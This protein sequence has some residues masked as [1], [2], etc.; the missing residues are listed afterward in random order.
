MQTPETNT[1]LDIGIHNLS[2]QSLTQQ[3]LQILRKGLSFSPTPV[4]DTRRT[5]KEILSNFDDFSNSLRTS[6]NQRRP[7]PPP[8]YTSKQQTTTTTTNT[9]FI[10]RTMKFI[11]K[12]T[13]RTQVEQFSGIQT[14][15]N[16]IQNTKN[17]LDEALP[18]ICKNTKINITRTQRKVITALQK[19]RNITTI[20]P[21]DKNLGI[22]I[23][24][25]DDYIQQCTSLLSDTS[26]YKIAQIF[27]SS[28]I[29][30]KVANTI[31]AFR[32]QIRNHHR[33]LYTYL[34]PTSKHQ[35]IPT[36]YGIPKI[37][38]KFTKLPPMRP[39][40]AH[41]SSP[42]VPSARFID[43]TLQPLARSYPDYLHNSTS[44]ILQLQDTHVPSNAI[45][46]T[47][48]VL[49]LYPSIPQSECLQIIYDEMHTH[50][51]LLFNPNLIVRLLDININY[52]YFDFAGI[53]FQ[54]IK[55]TAMGA[56]FSPTVANIFL[57]VVLRKFLA[58]QLHKPL[59]IARYIDDIFMI[60]PEENTLG[61]FL[62]ALNNFHPSLNPL[63]PVDVCTRHPYTGHEIR[64]TAADV[65]ASGDFQRSRL[66]STNAHRPVTPP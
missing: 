4:F 7:A 17:T 57:S 39:I 31:A 24:D 8:N 53:I 19:T 40:V 18:S 61:T 27:P 14:L 44:L 49:S 15:E 16:Y 20:K 65:I 45:L 22:V 41:S 30:K 52:N 10:H 38:K 50:Q 34:T 23:M 11:P 3:T 9:E 26:T 56:A 1:R 63:Y 54:Q 47:I 25:T 48:D 58:T 13:P 64:M 35:Q 51:H 43:H 42:L 36:F 29:T 62:T 59:L 60:W 28:T 66:D 33:H 21:A 2:S 55:G 12:T 37:H 5:H 6:T 46:V 32:Q